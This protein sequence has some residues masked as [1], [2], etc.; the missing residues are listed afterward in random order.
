MPCSSGTA[1]PHGRDRPLPELRRICDRLLCPRR[2][3]LALP[4]AAGSE[5]LATATRSPSIRQMALRMRRPG[6]GG[7]RARRE[8][9]APY[10]PATT[11]SRRRGTNYRQYGPQNSRRFGREGLARAAP[12]AVGYE[13]MIA[14]RALARRLYDS[15]RARA[16]AGRTT[17]HAIPVVPHDLQTRER[18][19]L[20]DLC[21]S[22]LGGAAGRFERDRQQV[23]AARLRRELRTALRTWAPRIVT[24]RRRRCRR[25][26]A[27]RPTERGHAWNL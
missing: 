1:S 4:D 21:L 23:P 22:P 17:Q 9:R 26:P 12:V 10:R 24:L 7:A 25:C 3:A 14:R 18:G 8:P 16:R 13:G 5:R 11:T 27:G 2:L 20:G 15:P 6:P 19:R